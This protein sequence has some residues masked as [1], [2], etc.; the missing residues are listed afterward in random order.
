MTSAATNTSQQIGAS[1]GTAL[2]NTLAATAAASYLVAH[3]GGAGAVAAATVH[4]FASAAAWAAGS[5]A[6]GAVVGG[7][8]IDARPVAP[9]ARPALAE[10]A[11][12]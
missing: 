9:G 2:L 7:L 11:A 10:A 12:A 1:V 8:L 5:L 4:G 6:L 3:P